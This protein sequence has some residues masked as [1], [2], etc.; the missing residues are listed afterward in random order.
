MSDPIEQTLEEVQVPV[1][2]SDDDHRGGDCVQVLT[3]VS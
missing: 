3:P 1:Q 2:I